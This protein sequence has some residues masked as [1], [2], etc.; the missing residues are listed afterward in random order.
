MAYD[1][2]SDPD[3]RSVYDL[4]GEEGIKGGSSAQSETGNYS[5]SDIDSMSDLSCYDDSE[6]DEEEI[7]FTSFF[8]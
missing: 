2:L 6:E 1:I 5:E 3:K 8:G 7:S 4:A